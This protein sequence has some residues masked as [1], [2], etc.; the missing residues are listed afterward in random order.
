MPAIRTLLR[1]FLA[2]TVAA[3]L[4]ACNPDHDAGS[5]QPQASEALPSRTADAG[6]HRWR[7]TTWQVSIDVP[8]GW[9]IHHD[10]SAS[11]LAN[12]AW[13]TYAG[14]DSQGSPIVALVAP[15]SNHISDA[16]IRIGASRA[17]TE[18]RHC[19]TPPD[20]VR[21]GSLS[22]ETVGGIDFTTFEAADAAMSHYL[23]VHS[24]RTV[25]RGACYAI[26]LLVYGTNPQVFD[27]PVTPPFSRAEAFARM[28]S[29]LASFRLT[30]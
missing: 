7:D 18:V 14:P 21:P 1:I 8:P 27:P 26:D 20:A 12:G 16:E 10:F 11:Y 30:H 23:D 25:R 4:A 3:S 24:Y 29:V 13:K 28:R 5:H 9:T 6:V 17:P 19:A 2:I 15:G 22:H